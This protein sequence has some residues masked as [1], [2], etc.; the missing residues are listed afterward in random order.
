M[1]TYSHGDRTKT[2]YLSLS[3]RHQ[4]NTAIANINSIIQNHFQYYIGKNDT[5]KIR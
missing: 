1:Y 3:C 5:N 4:Y 2:L